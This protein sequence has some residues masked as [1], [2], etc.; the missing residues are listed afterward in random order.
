MGILLLGLVLIV[1]N[2]SDFKDVGQ[3]TLSLITL[4]ITTLSITTLSIKTLSI[5]TFNITVN[6]TRHSP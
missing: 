6:R 1:P 5:K 2:N 3:A 4:S